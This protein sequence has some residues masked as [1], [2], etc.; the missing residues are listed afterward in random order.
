MPEN[1][2]ITGIT[3]EYEAGAVPADVQCLKAVDRIFKTIDKSGINLSKTLIYLSGDR[4]AVFGTPTPEEEIDD[5]DPTFYNAL[6]DLIIAGAPE[7]A[8]IRAAAL[9]ENELK[10][11]DN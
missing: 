3:E 1:N 6:V 2:K 10:S 7:S 8:L 11:Y 5:E 4:V 9:I